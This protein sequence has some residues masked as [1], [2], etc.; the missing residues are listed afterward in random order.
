MVI[1]IRSSHVSCDDLL[2]PEVEPQS[3]MASKSHTNNLGNKLACTIR[4]VRTLLPVVY[5]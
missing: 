5:A 1:V 4:K 3:R 2:E